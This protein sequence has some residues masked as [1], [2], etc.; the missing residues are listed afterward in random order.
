MEDEI[1]FPISLESIM[2]M[3]LNYTH[4]KTVLEYILAKLST[5]EEAITELNKPPA[6]QF[7]T[8]KSFNVY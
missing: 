8:M 3:D 4:L 2:S 6:E 5:T 7:V 1:E